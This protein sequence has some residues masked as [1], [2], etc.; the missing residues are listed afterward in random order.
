MRKHVQGIDHVIILVRDLDRA[1]A[2]WQRLGFTLTARGFHS[3]G[4]QNHCV[5][6]GRDYIELMAVPRPHPSIRYFSDYLAAGEGLGGVVL[7][8]DDAEAAHAEFVASGIAAEP[9]LALSRPVA[10]LGDARFSLLQLPEALVPGCRLLLC[11]HHTR[12]IVWRPEYQSHALGALEI[13]GIA[14]VADSASAY[15]A[16]FDAQPQATPEGEILPSGSAPILISSLEKLGPRLGATL[17]PKRPPPMVAALFVRVADR[18]RA[19]EVLR[20]G[21]FSPHALKDGSF[22]VGAD[23]AN[24]VAL[25]FG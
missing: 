14:V 2:V 8:T 11:Q 20:D 13:A 21:G 15:A 22:A 3:L 16:V 24:G 23:E 4:S 18:A 17:L 9:P 6:L 12:E 7:A 1:Q 5:M 25:V 19:A 10:G